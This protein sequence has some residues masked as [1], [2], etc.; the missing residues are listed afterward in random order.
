M[1]RR[2]TNILPHPN[3]SACY[4]HLCI[5]VL[6]LWNN[7]TDCLIEPVI[8][9]LDLYSVKLTG[10]QVPKLSSKIVCILRQSG[11]DPKTVQRSDATGEI[12]IM[13]SPLG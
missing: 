6:V 2:D 10:S 3:V 1:D 13:P 9:N 4:M 11:L 12:I 5:M 8:P 7:A